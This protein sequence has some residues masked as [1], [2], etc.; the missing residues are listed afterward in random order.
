M[1]RRMLRITT[2]CAAITALT[3]AACGDSAGPAGGSA[4]A[5]ASDSSNPSGPD[6][7][8][9]SADGPGDVDLTPDAEADVDSPLDPPPS[10]V[11]TADPFIATGG[12]GFNVGSG[13]PGPKMPFGMLHVSPDTDGPYFGAAAY[14]CG[15]YH[16]DDDLIIGFSHTHLYGVGIP[17]YGNVLLMPTV[18]ELEPAMSD[19]TA[20]RSSFSKDA[21][22]ASPGYYSVHLDASDVEAE[23]T[24][25][26]RAA[27]HRYTWPAAD[28]EATGLVVL[29]LGHTTPSGEVTDTSLEISADGGTF[30]GWVHNRNAFSG[31][32]GGITI[33]FSGR[34][35][36]PPVAWGTWADGDY[37]AAVAD[38]SGPNTGALLQFNVAGISAVEAQVAISFVSVANAAANLDAEMPIWDFDATQD[39]A[40]DAWAEVLDRVRVWGGRDRDRIVLASAIYHS[41][42]MPNVFQDVSGEYLGFDGEVHTAEGFVYYTDFSMWDTY[43]TQHPLLTLIAPEYQRDMVVSLLTMAEQGGFLPKWPQGHGYTSAMLGTP[44][45]IVIADSYVKGITDF[46]VDFA[47][48]EMLELAEAPSP[49]GSGYEGRGGV[50]SYL[51][52]GYVAADEHDGSVARTLEFG[53][54]DFAIANLARAL[55]EDAVADAAMERSRGYEHLWDPETEFLRGRT[56]AGEWTPLDP[57][58][59]EE[60]YVEGNAWHYTWMV[61]WDMEGLVGLFDTPE[62]FIAKLETFFEEGRAEVD[63]ILKGGEDALLQQL[64]PLNHYWH[65]NEPDIHAAYLFLAADRPDLTQKWVRWIGDT[66][67]TEEPNGL[68]GN[69]D[70]GTLSAWYVFSA[71]GLYPIPGSDR[72][73]LGVPFFPRAEIALP[74]GDVVIEAAGASSDTFYV[75]GVALDGVPLEVPWVTHADLASGA[76]LTF[77]LSDTPGTWGAWDSA[78]WS[79]AD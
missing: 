38:R 73:L 69:D 30:S 39:A 58:A 50:D 61:P 12:V 60:F 42:Q 78:R 52:H 54:A 43:R 11:E 53:H 5:D 49:P 45:D 18:G 66:L 48:A 65:S 24:A 9:D 29:D 3:L 57:F 23:L 75:H 4:D 68:A 79:A 16:A 32:Y 22:T 71:L 1:L 46:D 56:A 77:D 31:R 25:T 6:A 41:F 37:G 63:Y 36:R 15:G 20:Y 26:S 7:A 59:W 2:L 34:F 62:A 47:L 19:W 21:E 13:V 40:E 76:T 51:A 33:Y 72:Y 70:A 17:E 27:H 35:D 14:H 8:A 74:G 10:N 64:L 44:A 67:Y 55:G 28:A